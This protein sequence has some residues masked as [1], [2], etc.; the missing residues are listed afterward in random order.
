M[1]SVGSDVKMP[2]PRVNVTPDEIAQVVAAFYGR[3]VQH[4]VLG[5]VFFGILSRDATLWREHKAKIA[6]F[7]CNALPYKGCYTG[8]PM[9]VHRGISTLM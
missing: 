2:D 5:P 1:W 7:W 6:E 4:P 9:L 3:A 8:N